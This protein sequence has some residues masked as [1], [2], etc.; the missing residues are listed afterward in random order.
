MTREAHYYP[1]VERFL[2]ES[3]ECF[4]TQKTTGVQGVGYAD[5]LG[6]RD[7]GGEFHGGVEVIAVEVKLTPSNFGKSLGQAHGYSLF[8]NKC[9]L[10]V[11]FAKEE[12]FTAEQRE[13]AAHLGVGL[14]RIS[15]WRKKRNSE[16]LT[17]RS[18]EPIEALRLKALGRLGY[19]QCAVCATLIG[20]PRD[21]DYTTRPEVARAKGKVLYFDRQIKDGA[22]VRPL[23]FMRR[24][25]EAVRRQTYICPACVKKLIVPS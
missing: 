15:G 8:A 1:I 19:Y 18:D 5:V 20:P 25:T 22:R 14:I 13:E 4:V 2:K 23:M 17:P 9:Y 3:L 21:S 12:S 10:A 24:K 11:P 6:V 7:I 16:A